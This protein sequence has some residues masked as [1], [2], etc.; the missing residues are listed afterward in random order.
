MN[1]S[2]HQRVYLY[3]P[4]VT[5][6][7]LPHYVF[8]TQHVAVEINF[9]H[10]AASLAPEIGELT[11]QEKYNLEKADQKTL[12]SAVTRQQRRLKYGSK[13]LKPLVVV[14]AYGGYFEEDDL[15]IEEPPDKP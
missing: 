3:V 1:E 12:K 14:Y 13:W 15:D 8:A 10:L 11:E 6:Y 9:G 5:K 2:S 7:W 4:K